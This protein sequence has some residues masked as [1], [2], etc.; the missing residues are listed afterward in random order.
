MYQVENCY[1]A[2]QHDQIVSTVATY[3]QDCG[4]A[5]ADFNQGIARQESSYGYIGRIH[6]FSYEYIYIAIYF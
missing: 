5:A 2:V 6:F 3:E 1:T 4:L